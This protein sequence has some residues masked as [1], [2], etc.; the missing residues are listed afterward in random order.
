MTCQAAHTAQ[1]MKSVQLGTERACAVDPPPASPCTQGH[2]PLMHILAAQRQDAELGDCSADLCHAGVR[3][4]VGLQRS[5][6]SSS[7]SALLQRAHD[8]RV[9]T[10]PA[11]VQRPPTCQ[12]KL[13]QNTQL[14]VELTADDLRLSNMYVQPA[15]RTQ[16]GV[17]RPSH[18]PG[19]HLFERGLHVAA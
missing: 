15:L 9:H 14:V 6:C 11:S 8:A 4:H 13:A 12:Q 10:G 7:R 18:I 2:A 16:H 17:C 5:A 1:G 19:A 3:D